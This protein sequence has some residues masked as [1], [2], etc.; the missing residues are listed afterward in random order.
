MLIQEILKS[1]CLGNAISDSLRGT[2][3]Q[4]TAKG[5]AP[6]SCLFY[7]SLQFLASKQRQKQGAAKLRKARVF[8]IILKK[9]P[10]VF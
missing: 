4:I 8:Y 1:R 5:N 9:D 6:F 10:G 3:Q 7:T 2:F